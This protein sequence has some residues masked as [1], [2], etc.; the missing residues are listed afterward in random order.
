MALVMLTRLIF[1]S[2]GAFWAYQEYCM[3]HLL[4]RKNEVKSISKRGFLA[5]DGS[6]HHPNSLENIK[7]TSLAIVREGE[8]NV[9]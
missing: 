2:L 5:I 3:F 1:Y 4:S 8:Y 7:I 9:T 6:Y